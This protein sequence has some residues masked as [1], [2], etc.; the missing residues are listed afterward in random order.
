M[1]NHG[2][3]NGKAVFWIRAA[4]F[5]AFGLIGP[6]FFIMWRYGVLTGEAT[7]GSLWGFWTILAGIVSYIIIRYIAREIDAVFPESMGAQL[8]RGFVS[9]VVPL[10]IVY[11]VLG[12]LDDTIEELT[13]CVLA[14]TLCEA[15]AIVV[16][17]FPRLAREK[18]LELKSKTIK[19]AVKAVMEA[20]KGDK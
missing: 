17:P 11:L 20:L 5:L 2:S 7:Q 1:D 15:V 18:G 3:K 9:V 14:C 19:E 10:L 4:L 12:A 8:L 6:L 13:D 16:N